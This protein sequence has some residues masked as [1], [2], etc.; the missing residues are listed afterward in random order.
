MQAKTKILTLLEKDGLAFSGLGNLFSFISETY[1]ISMEEVKKDFDKLLKEG[2]IFEI[3]KGK[4]ITIPS[5]GYVK[6]NFI[7]NG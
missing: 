2:L 6:A 5:H 1:S 7:G 4:F 3:S